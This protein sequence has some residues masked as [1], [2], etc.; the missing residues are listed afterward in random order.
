[1]PIF[2]ANFPKIRAPNKGPPTNIEKKSVLRY[3][4]TSRICY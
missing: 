2:Q 1:M 3:A 4:E